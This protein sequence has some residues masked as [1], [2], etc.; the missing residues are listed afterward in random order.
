MKVKRWFRY[1]YLRFVVSLRNKS[2]RLLKKVESE[3]VEDMDQIQKLVYTICLRLIHNPNSELISSNIDYTYHIENEDYLIVIR[4]SFNHYSITL[5]EYKQRLLVNSFD[6]IFQVP[7]VKVIIE[8]FD[9]EISKRMKTNQ[10]LKT[11]KVAKHLQQ[12]LIE[13]EG[14]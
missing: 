2:T 3:Q 11:A 10:L 7:H 13:I 14:K 9:R 6:V 4:P 1:R 12:I 5:I 8:N